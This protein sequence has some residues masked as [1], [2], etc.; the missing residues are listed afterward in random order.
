MAPDSPLRAS[1][2]EPA[3]AAAGP[4]FDAIDTLVMNLIG[5]ELGARGMGLGRFDQLSPGLR[6]YLRA[7]YF[8]I[9]QAQPRD[10]LPG[11]LLGLVREPAAAPARYTA[12]W[13]DG[14]QLSGDDLGPWG[15]PY[16]Q[17]R[18]AGRALFSEHSPVRWV[19]DHATAP[20]KEPESFVEFCCGGDRL[21]GRVIA[22]YNA[23]QS[24]AETL[25]S[26]LLVAADSSLDR[27]GTPART[28]LRIPTR[29][30][31][32]VVWQPI[33]SRY[34]PGTLF[35]RDGRQSA[36]RLLRWGDESVRLLREEGVEEV[37]LAAIAELHLPVQDAWD[38]CFEQWAGLGPGG[39]TRIVQLETSR[40][41]RVTSSGERFQA[42]RNRAEADPTKAAAWF[43]IVQPVW[44]MD[45]LWVPYGQIR[46]RRYY[47]AQRVPLSSLEPTA[48]RRQSIL[49]GAWQWLADRNVQGG[50]LEAAGR[51][52]GWGFGVQAASE[53]EFT[54]P[55]CARTFQTRL[56][57]DR[58]A[59]EGGC[60]RAAVLLDAGGRK[61]LY[62]SPLL[63]GSGEVLD[64]GP[65]R[66][67]L[68][69]GVAARLVLR[70]E[71]PGD[72]RPAQ[73]D[74]W[75]IRAIF[76]W[77]EP[78]LELDP[79]QL[80]AEADRRTT[81]LIPAWQDW[82]VAPRSAPGLRLVNYWNEE[83]PDHRGGADRS[84]YRLGVVAVGEPLR[85]SRVIR[86]S[87]QRDRLVLS[88]RRPPL[89]T[90]SHIEIRVDGRMVGEF[91]VPEVHYPPPPRGPK[92]PKHNNPRRPQEAPLAQTPE[93]LEVSLA[94]YR[95]RQIT[96]EIVQQGQDARAMV[97]WRRLDV[98][99]SEP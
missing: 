17:P 75:D 36:Y 60:V 27:P 68:P 26:Y 7:I 22:A 29:W 51:L 79:A 54:M 25:P 64:T 20:G 81:R 56:G 50:P 59:G 45:P 96:I 5:E 63:L 97:D 1:L 47:G 58:A 74:P 85:V 18:L 44:S 2:G 95:D 34:Q 8:H 48:S 16:D 35:H 12:V 88:V 40:G 38:A 77:L 46:L 28:G 43:H 21:P 91:T 83:G 73:A 24:P 90:P 33:A 86:V 67:E 99:G 69:A 89:A 76:D 30:V 92:R 57:L 39:R 98:V 37:P 72:D 87:P 70:A 32:R 6:R 4:P 61:A 3:P 82:T 15:D 14:T 42:D 9:Y 52:Y 23:T 53:L 10:P 55:A 65:L 13:E 41:L 71:L 66:L 62:A 49:G 78:Q 94:D 93:A 84:G 80:Q 19:V 11:R 31:R